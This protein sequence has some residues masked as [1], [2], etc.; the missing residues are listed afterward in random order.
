MTDYNRGSPAPVPECQAN[1]LPTFTVAK[2]KSSF[3]LPPHRVPG[4]Y[5]TRPSGAEMTQQAEVFS[6]IFNRS[7][8][9][10]GLPTCYY[11]TTSVSL[12]PGEPMSPA[13]A[14]T[15]PPLYALTSVM[16]QCIRAAGRVFHLA[17]SCLPS[18][19]WGNVECD[20][21]FI[22]VFVWSSHLRVCLSSVTSALLILFFVFVG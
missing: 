10:S 12:C 3:E 1:G 16:T 22:S 21:I 5:G 11:R 20:L 18:R 8:S 9:L 14:T 4:L 15:A 19:T 13:W 7:L 17:L 2:V 6:D